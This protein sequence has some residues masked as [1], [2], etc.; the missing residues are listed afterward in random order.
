MSDMD[1]RSSCSSDSVA[2]S[3]LSESAADLDTTNHGIFEAQAAMATQAGRMSQFASGDTT[4]IHFAHVADMLRVHDFRF[5]GRSQPGADK[6]LRESFVAMKRLWMSHSFTA[7]VLT[8]TELT[9]WKFTKDSSLNTGGVLGSFMG[10]VLEVARDDDACDSVVEA[11]FDL[12]DAIARS[13]CT[14]AD[15]TLLRARSPSFT[16]EDVSHYGFTAAVLRELTAAAFGENAKTIRASRPATSLRATQ[17]LLTYVKRGSSDPP[18]EKRADDMLRAGMLERLTSHISELV[19]S[20]EDAAMVGCDGERRESGASDAS[21][22]GKVSIES[23]GHADGEE[24]RVRAERVRDRSRDDQ[25]LHA[26]LALVNSV[27]RATT[28]HM[29]DVVPGSMEGVNRVASE[30]TGTAVCLMLDD[31]RAFALAANSKR[32]A[33]E[34]VTA[35][36]RYRPRGPRGRDTKIYAIRASAILPDALIGWRMYIFRCVS[37]REGDP[38]HRAYDDEKSRRRSAAERRSST[39]TFYRDAPAFDN[40]LTAADVGLALRDAAELFE[41]D[42]A[43]TGSAK[44][45]EEVER[46]REFEVRNKVATRALADLAV[47]ATSRGFYSL[48]CSMHWHA[49]CAHAGAVLHAALFARAEGDALAWA[50]PGYAQGT[51]DLLLA[52]ADLEERCRGTVH[53]SSLARRAASILAST[54]ARIRERRVRA[55]TSEASVF[56]KRAPPARKRKRRERY[57]V[58]ETNGRRFYELM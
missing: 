5:D 31:H 57:R 20:R 43:E 9:M 39:E 33:L 24:H 58:T 3:D 42:D 2:A 13:R 22:S 21:Y 35:M 14:E 11:G 37:A 30:L 55:V 27:L 1:S 41:M 34:A 48:G 36:A 6:F 45:F 12:L 28:V 23:V 46:I 50:K 49:M 32:K 15:R 40:R 51:P 17:T 4:A 47:L 7:R 25:R 19:N 52:A 29:D 56:E 8:L 16:E 38:F 44:W 26:C 53:A 10:F 54:S 18:V